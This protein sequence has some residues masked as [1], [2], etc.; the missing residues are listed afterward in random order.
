MPLHEG[1]TLALSPAHFFV[2]IKTSVSTLRTRT[3]ANGLNPKKLSL[4]LLRKPGTRGASGLQKTQKASPRGRIFASA[5]SSSVNDADNERPSSKMGMSKPRDCEE[6]I[7]LPD[8]FRDS[9]S[10]EEQPLKHSKTFSSVELSPPP[11]TPLRQLPPA[12]QAFFLFGSIT[13]MVCASF[14]A[15]AATAI[16]TLHAMRRAAMSMERLADTAQHELPGTMAAIRLSGLEISDLTLELS[17]LSQEV[18]ESL[19]NSAR[20][21]RAAE[22]GIRRMGSV[23]ASQTLSLLQEHASAPVEAVKPVVATAAETTRH[24][25]SQAHKAV[26]GLAGMPVLCNWIQRKKIEEQ[27]KIEEDLGLESDRELQK[28]GGTELLDDP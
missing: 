8:H 14:I 7:A 11:L 21:V 4:S 10:A 9:F 1:A 3:S 19:R 26:L 27:K 12:D 5:G 20:A 28:Q 18:S 23:A 17:D 16:P 22:V 2:S 15:M 6:E 13:F 24:A 25:M